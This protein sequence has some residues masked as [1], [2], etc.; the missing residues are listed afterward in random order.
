MNT[1]SMVTY[2]L[3]ASVATGLTSLAVN[4]INNKLQ[5][6]DL[7]KDLKKMNKRLEVRRRESLA[8]NSDGK[9]TR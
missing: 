6:K 4:R 5:K 8:K 3:I 7:E 2:I 1:G 9:K